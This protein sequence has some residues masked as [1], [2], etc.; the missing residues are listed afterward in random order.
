V[1]E[2]LRIRDLA[3]VE[4]A[5]LEFGPGLNVLTGETGAGKS[6]VLGALGLLAGGRA[7]TG[8][9]R[10]GALEAVVEAVF[11]ARGVAGLEAA[12]AERGIELDDGALVVRRSVA[13]AETNG[14]TA[15]RSRAQLAGQLVPIATLAEVLGGRLEISSQHESQALLR[16]ESHGRLLDA[17]AGALALRD[18]VAAGHAALRALDAELARLRGAAE[19]RARRQD[20]LAFQANEIDEAK[21][22]PG[23]HAALGAERAR[24][25]HASRLAADAAVAAACI[26]GESDE[27]AAARDRV[28]EAARRIDAAARLDPG[29]EPLAARLRA[30]GAELDDAAR[31]LERYA[32]GIEHDP[33][34]AGA[35]EERL[36]LLEKLRRKYGNDED[37]ILAFRA[38]IGAERA[39]LGNSDERLA[40]LERER[41]IARSAL[42]DAAAALTGARRRGAKALAAALEAALG[43]LAMPGAHFEIALPGYS[44]PAGEP[45]LRAGP[46]VSSVSSVPSAASGPSVPSAA[47][48]SPVPP[49]ASPPSVPS[50][51][52]GP[53]GAEEPEILFS[54]NPG[55]AARPLRRVASGGELSRVF[56]AL[57]NVLR[58]TG[59]G[60]VLVFDEVDAGIGG[61]VADRVGRALAELA[62]EHQ[63]LCITHL[64][65]IAA[66]ASHHFRVRKTSRGGRTVTEVIALAPEA[67]V[68]EIA[69]M[70]GGETVTDA[71][72]RHAEALLRE[73]S[74]GARAAGALPEV[75]RT[76]RRRGGAPPVK[77]SIRPPM[78][79]P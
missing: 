28:A 19:E 32:A 45:E 10:E 63:V 72:R 61:A 50:L 67:R 1:I 75:P 48:V 44:P 74:T 42:A 47:P 5:E 59:A 4:T 49:A 68:E 62:S 34:R 77:G 8:L 41:G 11:Q 2:T 73:A 52:C 16:P 26:A 51:P 36:A 69:R 29:L 17:H 30:L 78:K 15:R 79:R 76:T 24:L 37:A 65:Q 23:E 9:V 6:I 20:F 70:A 54:A 13:A 3:L 22:H 46:S 43:E 53:R 39:E 71:T 27:S 38:R 35:I 64:P 66:R 12:L 40:Q 60:M 33:E 31:E 55:E 58:R 21:L 56:L 25:V 7:E 18:A 57:K 14:A